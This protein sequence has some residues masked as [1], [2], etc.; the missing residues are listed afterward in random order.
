MKTEND[1]VPVIDNAK[2]IYCDLCFEIC[3]NAA[4]LKEPNPSCDKCI[5][6][7]FSMEV[8]CNRDKYVFCYDRCD[9]CGLCLSVCNH[10]AISWEN[11]NNHPK[12]R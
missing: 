2:C 9:T 10:E 1:H 6:Y 5:K 11:Y 7:C 8:P 3:P 4:I 12:V